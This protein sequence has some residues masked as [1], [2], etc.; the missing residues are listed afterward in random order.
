MIATTVFHESFYSFFS[1]MLYFPQQTLH[2]NSLPIHPRVL[3]A[4]HISAAPFLPADTPADIP[5]IVTQM[6]LSFCAAKASH[7]TIP[8]H[9]I[10]RFVLSPF[11]ANMRD[12][13]IKNIEPNR[14]FTILI[15]LTVIFSIWYFLF[16]VVNAPLVVCFTPHVLHDIILYRIS[17]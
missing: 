16:V 15:V 10:K 5:H 8:I 1:S 13:R 4:T 6:V 17:A 2:F 11:Y 3:C 7:L 12:I 9:Q 14:I